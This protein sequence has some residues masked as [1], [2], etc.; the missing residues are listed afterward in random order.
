MR[1]KLAFGH[2]SGS[3][4]RFQLLPPAL[5][6][7]HGLETEF[8]ALTL[9]ENGVLHL[10]QLLHDHLDAVG[11]HQTALCQES[12]K[13]KKED[14]VFFIFC[15]F[16]LSKDRRLLLP[17][18]FARFTDPSFYNTSSPLGVNLVPRGELGL[19]G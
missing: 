12:L 3:L 9:L 2:P 8:S 1:S 11:I 14:G 10:A 5:G 13:N 18:N 7:V 6:L 15:F 17:K 4:V 16:S 19:Q